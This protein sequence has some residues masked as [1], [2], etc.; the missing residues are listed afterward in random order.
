M[1]GRHGFD[2]RA[3]KALAVVFSALLVAG[4]GGGDDEGDGSVADD[5]GAGGGGTT[6]STGRFVDA[7]VEGLAYACGSASGHTGAGGEFQYP[8][9]ANCSFRIGGV[10][11][12]SA[13][14]A[15]VVTPVALVDGAS[16]ETHPAVQNIVRFLLSLDV[17]GN[18]ANGI[19]IAAAVRTAL[20]GVATPDFGAAGFGTQAAALVQQAIA[21]RGLVDAATAANHL[22]G[23]L[24]GGID[25]RY[26]CSYAGAASGSVTLTIAGGV[27]T[28]SGSGGFTLAG[29]ALSSGRATIGSTSSGAS[30]TGS[31]GPDG[32]GSGTW[33]DGPAASGTWSCVRG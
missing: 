22:R 10:T 16:D 8:P 4:C 28:G 27:I 13:A 31:F 1:N 30:F 24:L 29:T 17:D 2:G 20:V 32:R 23:T 11:L 7:P 21:G 6:L 33:S 9:G 26:G 12:G 14:A 3:P 19:T 18:P 15:A 5:G 25:G